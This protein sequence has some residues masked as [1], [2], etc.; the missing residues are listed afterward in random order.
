LQPASAAT[1]S[2]GSIEYQPEAF[3]DQI[4]Q[5]FT[6]KGSACFCLSKELIFD[7]QSGFHLSIF[8]EIWGTVKKVG[9][10]GSCFT[11]GRGGF[12]RKQ[13][14][15]DQFSGLNPDAPAKTLD[16]LTKTPTPTHDHE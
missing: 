4:A 16:T 3:F 2:I 1:R 15:R 12:V 13:F 10:H 9:D 7:L 11:S 6:L 5:A 8:M 14:W